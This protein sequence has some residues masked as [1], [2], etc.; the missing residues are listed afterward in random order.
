LT[1]LADEAGMSRLWGGI[2]FPSDIRVGLALGRAVAQ[3]VV[4]RAQDD[5]SR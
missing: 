4:E 3:R 1:A 2:H 5:G